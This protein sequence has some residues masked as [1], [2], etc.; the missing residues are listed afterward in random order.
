MARG[1][2]RSRKAFVSLAKNDLRPAYKESGRPKATAHGGKP[3]LAYFFTRPDSISPDHLP[4]GVPG[5]SMNSLKRFKSF[6]TLRGVAWASLSP[7]SPTTP[8]GGS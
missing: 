3:K 6:S 8:A 2:Q 7:A 4:V 5:I 1:R